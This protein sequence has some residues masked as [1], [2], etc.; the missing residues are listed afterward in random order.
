[1]GLEKKLEK[2]AT[3]VA[4][5][6]GWYTRKFSSPSNRGVPD[7]IFIKEC[8]VWFIEFKAPGNTPTKL[9]EYEMQQIAEHGGRVIY[10]DNI[11]DFKKLLRINT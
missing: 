9:Q 10:L 3:D 1:M 7:R 2:R 8:I 5:A 4:K 6:N 11:D